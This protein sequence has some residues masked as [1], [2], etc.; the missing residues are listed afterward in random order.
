MSE[1]KTFLESDGILVT[2]NAGNQYLLFPINT[3]PTTT[4]NSTPEGLLFSLG[5][6]NTFAG[7]K[8]VLT[9]VEL[10]K[11][12]P[13]Y[14]TSFC[15]NLYPEIAKKHNTKVHSV[16]K[17]LRYMITSS[18]KTEKYKKLFGGTKNMTNRRFILAFINILES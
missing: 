4:H 2:D 7:F 10:I 16:E 18:K 5:F 14:K 6:S 13:N 11:E 9:A 8:Y 17:E 15:A 12:H 3:S 1:V